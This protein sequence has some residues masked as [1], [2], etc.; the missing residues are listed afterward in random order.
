MRTNGNGAV[1]DDLDSI[2]DELVACRADPL[3]FV[4]TMF[5]WDG[6]ELKGGGPEPWQQEVLEAIR[7]G[8]PLGQSC[9]TGGRQWP[10]HRQDGARKLDCVV[11][12]Q[13]MPGLSWNPDGIE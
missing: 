6:P 9:A 3:L 13:H 10:R 11:G 8:L 1:S 12:N 2:A 7:D 5:P 4:R